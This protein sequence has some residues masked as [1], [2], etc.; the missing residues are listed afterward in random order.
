MAFLFWVHPWHKILRFIPQANLHFTPW[1]L[2]NVM[3]S[4]PPPPPRIR[5]DTS[6]VANMSVMT[7]TGAVI[8]P[9]VNRVH[10]NGGATAGAG[11]RP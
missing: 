8:G 10:R 9:G 2:S 5:M 1:L 11:N 7:V 4:Y 3:V 6:S